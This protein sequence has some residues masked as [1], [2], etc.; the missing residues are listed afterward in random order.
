MAWAMVPGEAQSP[1]EYTSLTL[2]ASASESSEVFTSQ[3]KGTT[4]SS[5]RVTLVP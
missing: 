4:A 3:G 2:P 5:S 1:T